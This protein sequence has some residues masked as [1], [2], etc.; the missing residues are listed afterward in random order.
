M[1]SNPGGRKSVL[2]PINDSGSSISCVRSLGRRGVRT[3][4]VSEHRDRPAFASRYCD[5]K[6]IVP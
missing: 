5:E 4:A 3:I 6:I 2:L 1:T